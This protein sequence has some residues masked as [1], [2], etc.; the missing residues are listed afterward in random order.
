MLSK[1][2]QGFNLREYLPWWNWA[3]ENLDMLL[4]LKDGIL[5]KKGGKLSLSKMLHQARDEYSANQE[6]SAIKLAELI[7]LVRDLDHLKR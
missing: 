4:E 7:S 6:I 3:V 1:Q 5:S 2:P